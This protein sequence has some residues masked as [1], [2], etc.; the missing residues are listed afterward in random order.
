M[1]KTSFEQRTL[2]QIRT[3]GPPLVTPAKGLLQS[4]ASANLNK[5]PPGINKSSKTVSIIIELHKPY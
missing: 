1:Y 2:N 5:N 4:M 3:E